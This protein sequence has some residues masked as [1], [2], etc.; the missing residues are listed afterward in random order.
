MY[1]NRFSNVF[2]S[3]KKGQIEE[4]FIHSYSKNDL[5]PLKLQSLYSKIN[6]FLEAE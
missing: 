5:L 3:G 4:L 2:S 6:P 1:N